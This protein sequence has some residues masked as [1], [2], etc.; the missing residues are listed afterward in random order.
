[1]KTKYMSSSKVCSNQNLVDI[2]K[3]LIFIHLRSAI[4]HCMVQYLSTCRI[5][6]E[7]R[8]SV[9]FCLSALVT[10]QKKSTNIDLLLDKGHRNNLI[11]QEVETQPNRES[12]KILLDITRTLPWQ[13]IAFCGSLSEKD[14]TR[15]F[16]QIVNL[17]STTF[18]PVQMV[19]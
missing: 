10:F 14:R 17:L 2:H 1:M 4:F 12:I 18:Y 15:N 3:T 6:C 5:F 8:C 11:E 19:G 16:R 13:G 7:K 9:L